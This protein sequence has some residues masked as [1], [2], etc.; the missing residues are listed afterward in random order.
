MADGDMIIDL[1]AVDFGAAETTLVTAG[2]MTASVFKYR[3]GVKALRIRNARGSILLLPYHGQQIWDAEFLGRRLTMKT[4]FDEPADTPNYLDNYG[5]FFLHCGMTAMGNPGPGDTHPLHGEIPNAKF[6]T[7]QLIV[8][9]DDAGPYMALTGGYE[10]RMSFTWHYLATPIVKLGANDSFVD[11]SLTVR[12]LF[13]R[14]MSLMYLAHINFRPADGGS[15]IDA[16]PND[17]KSIRLRTTLP[18]IF[19]P[20]QAFTDMIAEM[21]AD[22]SRHRRIIKGRAIDPELVMG[23]DFAGDANGEAHTLMEHTDGTGDFVTHRPSEL[24]R[25]VRWMTRTEDQDAIGIVL[26]ST[27]EAN[28]FKIENERGNVKFLQFGE[29]WSCTMR[30]GA[31]DQAATKALKA[32]ITGRG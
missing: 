3:S 29:S 28:G 12:N 23:M 27:A 17:P 22:I 31:L 10:H 21:S 6:Q 1:N 19:K 15:L 30:F 2:A 32:K 4:M 16:V 24:P 25:A 5:A 20:S 11:L 14:P 13:H 18:D 26:P 8:G 9:R 7:A